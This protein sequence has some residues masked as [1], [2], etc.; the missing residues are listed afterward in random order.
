MFPV[1]MFLRLCCFIQSDK[2]CLLIEVFAPLKF[3]VII[4]MARFKSVTLLYAF[5]LS[6]TLLPVFTF[7]VLKILINFNQLIELF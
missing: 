7:Y 3:H 5:Y 1:G 6:V 4:G 2:L